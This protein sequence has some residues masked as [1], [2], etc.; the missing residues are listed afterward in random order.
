MNSTIQVDDQIFF[1]CKWK[2]STKKKNTPF[3]VRN[4]TYEF[5]SSLLEVEPGRYIFDDKKSLYVLHDSNSGHSIKLSK[6]IYYSLVRE[7]KSKVPMYNNGT[8]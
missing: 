8:L 6:S 5:L 4:S 3:Y 1:I 2:E 7:A